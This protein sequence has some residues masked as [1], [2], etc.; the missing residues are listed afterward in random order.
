MDLD[1]EFRDVYQNLTKIEHD[2]CNKR[3]EALLSVIMAEKDRIY[4]DLK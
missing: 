1:Q 3:R 2:N 4:E